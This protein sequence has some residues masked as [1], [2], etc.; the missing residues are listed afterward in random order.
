MIKI[1]IQTVFEYDQERAAP[2]ES[3]I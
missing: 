3:L 1:K 2:F